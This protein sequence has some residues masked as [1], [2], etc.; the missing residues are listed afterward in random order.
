MGQY[1]QML[2]YQCAQRDSDGQKKKN[3]IL[4]TFEALYM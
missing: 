2:V 4:K 1:W 3:H